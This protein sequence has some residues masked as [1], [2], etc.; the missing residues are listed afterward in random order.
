MYAGTLGQ[1]KAMVLTTSA[2]Q[3]GGKKL[4]WE[5]WDVYRNVMDAF[6]EVINNPSI[7]LTI[8]SLMF[9]AIERFIVIMHDKTSAGGRLNTTRR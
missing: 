6:L 4:A 9:A 3:D 7:P 1:S 8:D 2:F 5:A